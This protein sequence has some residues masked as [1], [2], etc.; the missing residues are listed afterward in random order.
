MRAVIVLLLLAPAV[1]RAQQCVSCRSARCERMFWIPQCGATAPQASREP[2]TATAADT[3]SCNG[4]RPKLTVD[5]PAVLSEGQIVGIRIRSSCP[6]VLVVLYRD[7]AGHT[8]V[9][10]P[11]NEEPAP[12]ATPDKPAQLPSAREARANI[13][14]QAQLSQPHIA[15]HEAFVVV[16]FRQRQDF[17]RLKPRPDH[18]EFDAWH[19]QLTALPSSRWA[20][21]TAPYTIEPAASP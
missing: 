3:A 8:A 5:L 9:L 21:L 10:W 14:L 15:A 11:S 17:E 19:A 12:Q 1:A 6:A 20:E 13:V 7:S 16:A 4:R 2:P 18:F